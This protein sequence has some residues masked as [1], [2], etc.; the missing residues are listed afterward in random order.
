M[1]R[2]D[3]SGYGVGGSGGG[4]GNWRFRKLDMPVFDGVDPDG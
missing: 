4:P 2:N 3:G 1:G